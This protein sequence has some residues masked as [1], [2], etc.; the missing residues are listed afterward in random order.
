MAKN[1]RGRVYQCQK[2][3]NNIYKGEKSKVLLHFYRKHVAIDS[4][5][6]YCNICKFVTT[7]EKEL[8][9]HVLPNH[10]P[11]HLATVNATIT[12]GEI[13]N[14]SASLIKNTNIHIPSDLEIVRLSNEESSVVFAQRKKTK[15]SPDIIKCAMMENEISC[16]SPTSTENILNDIYEDQCLSPFSLNETDL[17]NKETVVGSAPRKSAYVVEDTMSD[18]PYNSSSS[19]SSTTSSTSN[20]SIVEELKFVKNEIKMLG[21]VMEEFL[22]DLE[23]LT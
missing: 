21:V 2:C 11:S 6:F 14:E 18:S 23:K 5:P 19:S 13:V 8:L 12:N 9:N 7:S 17:F 16:N 15:S 10:Y 3:T 22:H 20:S 1:Q 4:V